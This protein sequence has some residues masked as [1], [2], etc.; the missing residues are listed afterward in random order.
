MVGTCSSEMGLR[1]GIKGRSKDLLQRF[2][3][4][5]LSI[6]LQTP[7]IHCFT[8]TLSHKSNL[9]SL[10]HKHIPSRILHLH[11]LALSYHS[12]H[13]YTIFSSTSIL[14]PATSTLS[15]WHTKQHTTRPLP[16]PSLFLTNSSMHTL[17]PTAMQSLLLRLQNQSALV[18]EPTVILAI[19]RLQAVM[20]E[21]L[22]TTTAHLPPTA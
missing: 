10:Y 8:N 17:P 22:A 14:L 19:L 3:F 2:S 21:A 13:H 12:S 5:S 4:S 20:P 15:Q 9:T 1:R 6:R 16:S 7:R 11:L 18:L